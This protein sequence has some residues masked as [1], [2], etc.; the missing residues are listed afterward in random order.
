M[1]TQPPALVSY[2]T[3]GSGPSS[4]TAD[5][6]RLP[7]SPYRKENL[8]MTLPDITEV[9]PAKED[10]RQKCLKRRRYGASHPDMFLS[11]TGIRY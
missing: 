1:E 8:Q 3:S 4:A 7:K 9:R 10:N 5:A 6:A 11:R 2:K